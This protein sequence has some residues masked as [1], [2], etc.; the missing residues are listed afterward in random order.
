[1]TKQIHWPIGKSWLKLESVKVY[2]VDHV[3]A[4]KHVEVHRP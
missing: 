4:W 2:S 3:K 1:M